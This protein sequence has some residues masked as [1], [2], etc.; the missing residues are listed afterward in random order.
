MPPRPLQAMS[1]FL[2]NLQHHA[3]WSRRLDIKKT[4]PDPH[5]LGAAPS[6]S[7]V[8]PR[9]SGLRPLWVSRPRIVIVMCIWRV[10]SASTLVNP[11]GKMPLH[12]P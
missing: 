9:R 1:V 6:T 4:E 12:R 8:F 11:K 5:Q 10:V 2:L 7:Q 3:P